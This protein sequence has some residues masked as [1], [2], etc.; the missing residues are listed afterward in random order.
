[1]NTIVIVT[2]IIFLLVV[3]II[4]APTGSRDCC[5]CKTPDYKEHEGLSNV[6]C[7]LETCEKCGH[8]RESYF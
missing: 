4:I 2:L 8:T 5:E 6:F 7:P 1:M 3:V